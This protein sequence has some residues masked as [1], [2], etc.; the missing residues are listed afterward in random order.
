MGILDHTKTWFFTTATPPG[1]C[2]R[3]FADSLNGRGGAVLGSEWRVGT[4]GGPSAGNGARTAVATYEGR[5]GVIGVMTALSARAQREQSAALGSQLTF[6]ATGGEGGR[7]MCTMAMTRTTKVLLFFTA[8][9]RF[10]RSAM[11]RVARALRDTDA[12]LEVSKQ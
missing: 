12:Q 11:N 5:A 10:F 8:D 2:V 1:D 9:G 6:T 4:V 7:T 3:V